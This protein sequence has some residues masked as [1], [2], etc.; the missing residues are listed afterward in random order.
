MVYTPIIFYGRTVANL[1]CS[2]SLL[3]LSLPPPTPSPIFHTAVTLQVASPS[4]ISL[5]EGNPGDPQ[6]SF[7]V[8]VQ[9]LNVGGL[10][11]REVVVDFISVG[12]TAG[13]TY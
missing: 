11:Q 4:S 7:P 1:L 5:S 13:I 3:P 10:L 6:E 8:C 12:G 2:L 9:L